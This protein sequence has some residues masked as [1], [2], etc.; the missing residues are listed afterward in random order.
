V[1][2]GDGGYYGRLFLNVQGREPN[3]VVEPGRYEQVRDELIVAL[4][5][6][7]GP[8][9]EPLGT[10]VFKPQ[11]VYPD[12]RGVAPDLIVY[13]GDLA[14]RSVGSV[15]NRSIYT[16]ENDTGPDE[17]N[18]DWHGIF[19]LSTAGAPAPLRGELPEVSI[20]DVAPTLLA[21]LGLPVAEDMAGAPLA[22]A[23]P[24]G[25]LDRIPARVAS[26]GRA[27]RPLSVAPPIRNRC[28]ATRNIFA[29]SAT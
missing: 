8:D 18:H 26:Y 3:G 6:M 16:Y 10:K 23:L 24:R 9:G 4:E 15:G 17:A 14:W 11:D 12:V 28:G 7:P 29:R 19:V 1:A 20:Y 25:A 27:G 13:F 5:A 22:A 2:W 21:W